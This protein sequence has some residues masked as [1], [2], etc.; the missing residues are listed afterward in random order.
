MPRIRLTASANSGN[1]R[2]WYKHVTN[3]DCTKTNGYAFSGD[4][5]PEDTVVDIETGAIVIE[6]VPRGSV[7]HN[8]KEGK[9]YKI[10]AD[11]SSTLLFPDTTFDW[12]KDFLNFR[13]KVAEL[14][15]PK[16]KVQMVCSTCGSTNVRRD[17]QVAWNTDTQDWEL[18]A[19]FDHADCEDCGGE[20]NIEEQPLTG[21]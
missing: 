13:D 15:A 18:T 9:V 21:E 8:W 17:A 12:R 2:S 6:C 1:R 4:F 14:L 16:D 11:G 7:K 10:E 3:V 20:T 5:I 19:V